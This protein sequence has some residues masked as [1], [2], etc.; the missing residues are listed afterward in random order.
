MLRGQHRAEFE[1]GVQ[2]IGA[3]GR[4]SMI[5]LILATQRPETQVVPGIIKGNLPCRIA[6]QLPTASDSITILGHGGAERLAGRG[7]MLFEPPEGQAVRL[8]GY[9]A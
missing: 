2:S 5:H 9:S 6:L 7:D 3:T 1:A 8:Q 4:S